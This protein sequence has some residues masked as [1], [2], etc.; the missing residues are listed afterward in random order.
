MLHTR[1]VKRYSD[2][3]QAARPVPALPAFGRT[4]A[5]TRSRR[6]FRRSPA[7]ARYGNG[8]A[9]S[10]CPGT[11]TALGRVRAAGGPRGGAA[12]RELWCCDVLSPRRLKWRKP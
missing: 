12:V 9:P 7:T 10:R 6:H 3:G 2:D 5:P 8:A 4:A 11:G 1:A